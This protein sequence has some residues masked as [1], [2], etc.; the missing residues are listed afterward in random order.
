MSPTSSTETAV[1]TA[2][3]GTARTLSIRAPFPSTAAGS[4][5]RAPCGTESHARTA[6]AAGASARTRRAPGLPWRIEGLLRETLLA[7][8]A[9][10]PVPE[11]PHEAVPRTLP[12][13]GTS[14]P[15]STGK[16]EV[17]LLP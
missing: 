10:L 13:V 17:E 9:A 1:G 15:S 16:R 12:G 11:L 7:R 2:G 3:Q 8:P 5:R 14:E 6:G 4:A